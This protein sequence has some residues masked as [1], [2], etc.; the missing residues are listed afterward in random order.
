MR[1][2]LSIMLGALYVVT[3]QN[4]PSGWKLRWGTSWNQRLVSVCSGEVVLSERPPLPEPVR[5]GLKSHSRCD[6]LAVAPTHALVDRCGSLLLSNA[7]YLGAR[8]CSVELSSTSEVSLAVSALDAVQNVL[9]KSP[10]NS[11]ELRQRGKHVDYG[12]LNISAFA[13]TLRRISG[14]FRSVWW[15]AS[16][17]GR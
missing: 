5:V 16:K 2:A 3:A 17:R 6:K 13:R 7:E 8:N 10:P 1:P 15:Q 9:P 14:R 4:V 12:V 11:A